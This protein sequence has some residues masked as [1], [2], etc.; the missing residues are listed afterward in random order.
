MKKQNLKNDNA[1]TLVALVVT[2]VVLLILAGVSINLV[3]GNN[4]I[5]TKAQDAKLYSRAG[6]A[7]DEVNLWKNDNYLAA[8]MGEA[9]VDKEVML[10]GLL[11]KKFV[12]ADEI[13]RTNEVIK[14][15]KKDGTII[16]EISYKVEELYY[17]G[18]TT[19]REEAWGDPIVLLDKKTDELT[20]FS[21]AFII[22]NEE[23]IDITSI[24]Y[25]SEDET[26]SYIAPNELAWY[27]ED[28]GKLDSYHDIEDRAIFS[29]EKDGI[30]YSGE[31]DIG[32]EE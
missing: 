30:N 24:I 7:E 25:D 26:W 5:I 1:I 20:T 27:M 28:I 16:K 17:V 4:G 23:K 22:Y 3:I 31:A 32:W 19:I 14:I 9:L 13:D 29:L 2:I 12:N 6:S 18:N 11:D 15:K 8:N 21:R 10:Q